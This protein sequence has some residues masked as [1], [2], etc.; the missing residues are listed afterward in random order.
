MPAA[1]TATGAMATEEIETTTIADTA[2]A[3]R[4]TGVQATGTTTAE[5]TVI[6]AETWVET[7]IRGEMGEETE[8]LIR[9]AIAAGMGTAAATAMGEATGGA[10]VNSR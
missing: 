2:G 4:T 8:M 3:T 1:A 6:G 10:A 9:G 7:A 5:G